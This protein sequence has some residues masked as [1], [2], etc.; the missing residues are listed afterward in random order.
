[1]VLMR[2]RYSTTVHSFQ[3]LEGKPCAIEAKRVLLIVAPPFRSS[4]SWLVILV[5]IIL[6]KIQRHVA[7][8]L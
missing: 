1:M 3:R 6:G 7:E 8:Y 5:F 4:S 2:E